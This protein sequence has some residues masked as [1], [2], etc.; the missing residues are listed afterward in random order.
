MIKPFGLEPHVIAELTRHAL[1]ELAKV[2]E[3]RYN[4]V[5]SSVTRKVSGGHVE[6]SVGGGVRGG[7]H[8]AP[9][10]ILRFVEESHPGDPRNPSREDCFITGLLHPDGAEERMLRGFVTLEA[11]VSE[12]RKTPQDA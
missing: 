12:N 6:V 4:E 8:T 7:E 10:V 5:E 1:Y 9:H 11:L 3:G 2:R